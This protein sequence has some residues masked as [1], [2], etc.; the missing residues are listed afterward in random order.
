MSTSDKKMLNVRL[1][2]ELMVALKAAAEHD[3]RSVTNLIEVLIAE[4][5]T[6]VGIQL[7]KDSK[8]DKKIN[9]SP[10]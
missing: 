3:R 5:C 2:P 10:V 1:R 8:N 6:K 9:K 7:T 4:H